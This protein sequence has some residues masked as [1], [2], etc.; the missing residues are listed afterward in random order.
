MWWAL[1]RGKRPDRRRDD[2]HGALRIAASGFR[3][4]GVARVLV[5]NVAAGRP[6][7]AAIDQR[8]AITGFNPHR[9]DAHLRAA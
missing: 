9:M 1:R 7:F 3:E 5:E 2:G 4:R 6:G 8:W